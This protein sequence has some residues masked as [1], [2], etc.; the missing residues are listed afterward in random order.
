M[1]FPSGSDG[2]EI[3]FNFR[4]P[5]SIPGSGASPGEENGYP[6][7]YS[8]LENLKHRW[9]WSVAVHG[10]QRVRYYWATNTTCKRCISM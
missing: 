7:Q 1:G 4:D 9:A 6:L 8:C 10:L 3:A 2:K 5:G